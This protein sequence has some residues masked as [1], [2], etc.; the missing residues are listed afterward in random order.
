VASITFIC[1]PLSK[2]YEKRR[3]L[4]ERF[5]RKRLEKN[6]WI[7]WRGGLIGIHRRAVVYPNVYKKYALL[8]KLLME[9]HPEQYDL[10]Q[11]FCAVHHGMPDF[12]CYRKGVFT[13]VECKLAH[14]Q[15]SKR[16]RTCIEKLVHMGFD[17]EIHRLIERSMRA[18]NGEMHDWKIM[19]KEYQERMRVRYKK[20]KKT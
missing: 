19:V 8:E 14:E 17:V 18:R 13:F 12:I 7:V 3:G 15:I 4:S 9:K 1:V 2:E 11:L 5:H 16:Q 6:R 10:L 20:N